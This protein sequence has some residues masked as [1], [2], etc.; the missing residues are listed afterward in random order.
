MEVSP[1]HKGSLD[2]V[3]ERLRAK[4]FSKVAAES[5]TGGVVALDD[6]MPSMLY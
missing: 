4:G 2:E 3:V 5:F 1:R 6:P